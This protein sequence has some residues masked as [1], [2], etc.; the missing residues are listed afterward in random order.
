[1]IVVKGIVAWLLFGV[2]AAVMNSDPR[3]WRS[4]P[5][6][7][8]PVPNVPRAVA[9]RWP[10]QPVPSLLLRPKHRLLAVTE[11]R[12]AHLALCSLPH[13]RAPIIRRL[14]ARFPSQ[15]AEPP[16]NPSHRPPAALGDWAPVLSCPLRSGSGR[17]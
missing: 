2:I 8:Q 4:W 13:L 1:M 17:S 5:R 3:L 14:G 12:T 6:A 10:E 15:T 16:S 9:Q 11:T 7:G